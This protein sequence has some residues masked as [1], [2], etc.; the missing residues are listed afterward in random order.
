MSSWGIASKREGE[1][2]HFMVKC[3]KVKEPGGILE[4]EVKQMIRSEGGSSGEL[5]IS[6]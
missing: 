6:R 4:G 2:T 5:T 3:S 1:T